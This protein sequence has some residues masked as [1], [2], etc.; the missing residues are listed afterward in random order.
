M[1]SFGLALM[2]ITFPREFPTLLR[3]GWGHFIASW[4]PQRREIV[5]RNLASIGEWRCEAAADRA[6]NELFRQFA[7]KLADLWHFENGGSIDHWLDDWDGW[8]GFLAA[9]ARGK[10]VLL[11]T[12]HLGNWEFGGAFLVKRNIDL[13]VLTQAE[14]EAS[15][16]KLRQAS[17]ERKGIKTLVIGE[18]PF[19]FVEIIKRLQAG[20]TVA[21]LIDRPPPTNAGAVELF[22]RPFHASMAAA[23]IGA[24]R[25]QR[26]YPGIYR[27]QNQWLSARKFC[28]KLFMN[29]RR[30]ATVRP[31]FG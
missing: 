13:L 16:T 29:A 28:R 31:A 1:W 21:L 9:H 19:A 30:S 27:A 5:R 2:K 22:G 20:A 24:R 10:G 3:H 11:I 4:R 18:D 26:D 7:L 15:L 17:R 23:G 12:P 25:R 6:T 14:P 8:E